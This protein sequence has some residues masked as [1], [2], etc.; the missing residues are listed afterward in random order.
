MATEP[1]TL[2]AKLVDPAR[3]LRVLRELSPKLEV[4]GED[5]TWRRA[6]V[7]VG[8]WPLRKRLIVSHDPAYYS[9]PNWSIQMEGMRGYFSRFPG[10]PARERVLELI[11]QF[12][13]SL[14]TI[15]DPDL[16]NSDHRFTVI[17]ALAMELEAVWFTPSS[18]RDSTGRV[19]LAINPSEIDPEARWPTYAAA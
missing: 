17:Q 4:E 18:L 8:M 19:L 14:G 11:H 3:A 7:S 9:E 12:Q 5:E 13:F 6:V 1:I 16:T 2:F 15:V 10:V